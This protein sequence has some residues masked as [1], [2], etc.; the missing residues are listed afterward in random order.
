VTTADCTQQWHRL[1]DG[2]LCCASTSAAT[3]VTYVS[4]YR[5]GKESDEYDE[6]DLSEQHDD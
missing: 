5:G 2:R 1:D 6:T 4:S 3:S